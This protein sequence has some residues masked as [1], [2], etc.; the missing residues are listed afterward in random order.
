MKS[1][2]CSVKFYSLQIRDNCVPSS[3]NVLDVVESIIKEGGNEAPSE[4]TAEVIEARFQ[5]LINT[6][7][8]KHV[9]YK[10]DGDHVKVGPV[11]IERPY[12]TNN[13]ISTNPLAL[14]RTQ[15]MLVNVLV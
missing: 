11:R 12:R 2:D 3:S 8:E 7:N 5:R 6:L 4:E 15:A 14:Q 10:L 1:E 9:P 13:F